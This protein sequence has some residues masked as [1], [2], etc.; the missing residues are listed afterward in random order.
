MI[1]KNKRIPK[2]PNENCRK[3]MQEKTS[4]EIYACGFCNIN[5]E[6]NPELFE[7]ERFATEKLIEA[8]LILVAPRHLFRMPY[9]LHEKTSLASIVIDKN[10][11][12]DFQITDAK[13]FKVYVKNFY[14]NSKPGEAKN[15]LL[16]ALDWKEQQDKKEKI[17]ERNK[18]S[19][20]SSAIYSDL[21]KDKSDFKKISI[22]NPSEDIF[23]PC[24]KILLKGIKQDGR[25]RA[26]FVLLSFFTSLGMDYN[27][28]EKKVNNW[29]EKNYQ[30]LKKGYII[31]Q[32][33]W[34]KKAGSRMPPNCDNPI[35]KE[36]NICWP[37]NLCKI[38]KNPVN[39]A[40]KKYFSFQK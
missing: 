2:C 1:K 9:S 10:K 5:S 22:P 26:L 37:D 15:L 40:V 33:N 34:Y 30:P 6:K 25:K 8:D 32:L 7:E 11:I 23:P 20:K 28:I 24:I 27:E 19:S 39:Y 4:K 13:P 29:N 36:L 35:Y 3:I 14:P 12:Q 16:Q 18:E 21:K 31:S 38:I 17:I